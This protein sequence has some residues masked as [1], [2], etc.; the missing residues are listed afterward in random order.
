[1]IHPCDLPEESNKWSSADVVMEEPRDLRVVGLFGD[2]KLTCLGVW[3]YSEQLGSNVLVLAYG[4]LTV[5][6]PSTWREAAFTPLKFDGTGKR[7]PMGS[8]RTGVLQ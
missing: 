3:W 4:Q 5:Q 6:H 8:V 2:E 7:S 1:M